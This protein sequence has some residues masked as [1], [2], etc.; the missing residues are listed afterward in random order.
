MEEYTLTPQDS[1]Q[2][3]KLTVIILVAGARKGQ[4]PA[5]RLSSRGVWGKRS[6]LKQHRQY[7]KP[8]PNCSILIYAAHRPG[9]RIIPNEA[10]KVAAWGYAEQSIAAKRP[11]HWS[12]TRFRT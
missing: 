3:R 7:G 1:S 8:I 5:L 10:A 2:T 9:L 6:A 12:T 4:R 11:R